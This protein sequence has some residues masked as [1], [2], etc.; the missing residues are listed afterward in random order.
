[1]TKEAFDA[2]LLWLNT[3]REQAGRT[4]ESVRLRLIK[5][6]QWQGCPFYE[7]YADDAINRVAEKIYQGEQIRAK[8]PYI[9]FHSIARNILKEYLYKRK[10]ELAMI[11]HIMMNQH[12]NNNPDE[13]ERQ[14]DNR[15]IMEAKLEC[16]D[17]CLAELSDENR[18]LFIEYYSEEESIESRKL[19]A[20]RLGIPGGHLRI[21]IHRTRVTLEKCIKNCIQ[22]FD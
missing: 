21:K 22:G 18:K 16:L 5:F 7:E 15:L 12:S 20:D 2:L 8:D 14:Q 19:I 1:M 3:N 13:L 17:K 10:K 4:Y 6:F 9:Y 11:D